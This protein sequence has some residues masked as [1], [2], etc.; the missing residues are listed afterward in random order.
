V[1]LPNERCVV[2][3]A[4][5]PLDAYL[6]ASA[7]GDPA[8]QRAAMDEHARAVVSH[9]VALS[10]RDYQHLV[11]GS[12]D[13]VVLFVPGDAF[14][15]AAFD[16]R[17]DLFDLAARHDV[18]L[19]SPGTL[20]AFLRGVASGWRE[21]QVADEAQAVAELGR[22]LHE[23]IAT[24]ADHFAAVGASLGRAVGTYNQALGSLERR[25]LVTA[26]RFEQHGAGSHK[27]LPTTDAVAERPLLMSA[28]EL[29]GEQRDDSEVA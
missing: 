3:D 21:R 15:S 23:R 28:P 4:K 5:A 16:L 19:A 8:A 2:I 24:F 25:L 17:P 11:P 7:A 13:F 20:L 1:R 29:V 10:R 6:R 22:E 26:R 27:A 14:L 18:I 9:V 12:V